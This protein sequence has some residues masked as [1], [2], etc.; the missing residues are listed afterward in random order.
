MNPTYEIIVPHYGLDRRL[1]DVAVNFL[2]SVRKFTHNYRII[3]VDNGTPDSLFAPIQ[4]E[5]DKMPSVVVKMGYNSGF[6][7]AV[8]EGFKHLTN[9]PYVVICN[10]D[11]LAVNGWLEKLKRVFELVPTAGLCG[12]R[13]TATECW[14]GSFG[15]KPEGFSVLAKGSMLAFF[16]VMIKREVIDKLGGL[17]TRYGIGFGDDDDFCFLAQQEGYD[18]C[19]NTELIVPHL[20]RTTFRKLFSEDEVKNLQN[21]A[22][23]I[24]KDSGHH[25][26]YQGVRSNDS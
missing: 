15:I 9:A 21:K 26:K 3:F 8:N 22:M 4:R 6:V 18:L 23:E 1:T 20:H 24:L 13:T 16:C 19:L 11:I 12:P 14:Q 17:D 2:V 10:N 5:L 7:K 25:P